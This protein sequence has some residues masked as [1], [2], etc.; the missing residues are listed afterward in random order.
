MKA[1]HLNMIEQQLRA[2]GILNHRAVAILNQTDREMFVPD[3]LQ[4]IAFGDIQLIVGEQTKGEIMLAPK[5]IGRILQTLTELPAFA[6]DQC[7]EHI[8]LVGTGTGYSTAIF[9]PLAYRVTSIEISQPFSTLA[10]NNLKNAGISN[11]ELVVGN[12]L[13]VASGKFD[14]IILT[15]ATPIVPRIFGNLLN[16]NGSIFAFTGNAPAMQAQLITKLPND[17]WLTNTYF[18]TVIPVLQG[19]PKAE[20]FK[21]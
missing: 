12:A 8:L 17:A 21:F 11:C 5:I 20:E 7:V 18:E 1:S 13:E 3:H 19:L 15:A 6:N 14:Y 2:W 9:S 10:S 16:E 4:K